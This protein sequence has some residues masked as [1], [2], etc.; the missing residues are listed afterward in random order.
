MSG[1]DPDPTTE[2]G[3]CRRHLRQRRRQ[4][5]TLTNSTVSNNT[6]STFGGGIELYHGGSATL[7]DDT[8]ST[9]VDTWPMRTEVAVASPSS[10][11]TRRCP[12]TIQRTTVSGNAVDAG[13]RR[14]RGG[15]DVFNTSGTG[16]T[17][18]DDQHRPLD[19]QRQRDHRCREVTARGI[20]AFD[21]NW[22]VTDSTI[23]GNTGTAGSHR[24]WRV[25]LHAPLGST[26][27]FDTIA[28]NAA[29][30]ANSGGNVDVQSSS[31]LNVGESIVAGGMS[32]GSPD[33]C[34][35]GGGSVHSAGYNLI[36]DTSCGLQVRR[37]HHR[38]KPA[39]RSLANNGGPT[40][41]QLLPPPAP[42]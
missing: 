14:Q 33:N 29:A 34:S 35:V 37:R 25:H 3:D 41:G 30:S 24:R 39:A 7:T 4:Q 23:S 5:M 13:R 42:P 32:G 11:T 27:T 10:A 6:A 19:D 15:I 40:R 28:G 17:E 36:D 18:P 16:S 22:Q 9:K 2:E 21:G 26:W 20:D 8:I 38:S 12:M 1:G 31:T